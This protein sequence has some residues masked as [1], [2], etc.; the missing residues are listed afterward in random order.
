MDVDS[1]GEHRQEEQPGGHDDRGQDQHRG[2]ERM[3]HQRGGDEQAQEGQPQDDGRVALQLPSHLAEERAVG[4]E[5]H[6]REALAPAVD[7]AGE[8]LHGG[9]VHAGQGDVGHGDGADGAVGL[10]EAA[11]DPL[12]QVALRHRR[13]HRQHRVP[14]FHPGPGV[15]V[16]VAAGVFDHRP[17]VGD[18]LQPVR[19]VVGQEE[20]GHEEPRPIG[21]VDPV[22]VLFEQRLAH[23]VQGLGVVGH[24]QER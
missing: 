12:R 3:G 5:A 23:P 17:E 15:V 2:P 16:Q 9:G 22:R 7:V 14:G 6:V 21:T 4:G 13:V 8:A 19:L 18:G 24:D 1:E 20:R 10:A 11:P